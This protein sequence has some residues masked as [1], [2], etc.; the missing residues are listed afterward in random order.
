MGFRNEK[1]SRAATRRG[2]GQIPANELDKTY[3]DVGGPATAAEAR[4]PIP[5]KKTAQASEIKS[6]DATATVPTPTLAHTTAKS[7]VRGVRVCVY[8]GSRGGSCYAV[9]NR[10]TAPHLVPG[11]LVTACE[12]CF[13]GLREIYAEAL[14]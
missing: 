4:A 6:D 8:C 9:V 7:S 5:E 1:P 10:E 14:S 13:L 12:E 2:S 11:R 3:H